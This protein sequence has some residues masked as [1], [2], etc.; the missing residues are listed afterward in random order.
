MTYRTKASDHIE[1]GARVMLR[2]S[3]GETMGP[4]TVQELCGASAAPLRDYWMVK[5]DTGGRFGFSA[6]ALE[7]I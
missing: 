1:T 3:D 7:V 6:T 4:A 2:F 5:L